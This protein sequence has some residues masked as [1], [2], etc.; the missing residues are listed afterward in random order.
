MD[1][2][3]GLKLKSRVGIVMEFISTNLRK[4][5]E[6]D[7]RLKEKPNQINIAKQIVSGMNFLHSLDPYILV[8]H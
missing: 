1:Y 6:N 3:G 7:A 8:N 5:I 2:Y 4:A